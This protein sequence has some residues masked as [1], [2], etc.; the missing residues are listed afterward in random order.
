MSP[1]GLVPAVLAS[2]P[3]QRG[4]PHGEIILDLG[5]SI[6]LFSIII[7]SVLVIVLSINPFLF[8]RFLP[9]KNRGRIGVTSDIITDEDP[10]L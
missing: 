7:C 8:E 5:Y 9:A 4:L 1:K 3:L 10:E 2:L 6:V